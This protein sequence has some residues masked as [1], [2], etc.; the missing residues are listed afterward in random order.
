VRFDPAER[1]EAL[2]EFYREN[3]FKDEEKWV[4]KE[5]AAVREAK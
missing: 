2:A 3:G 4:A 1:Y 5:A